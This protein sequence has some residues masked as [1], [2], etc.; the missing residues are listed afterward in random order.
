M[1]ETSFGFLII[2]CYM[3]KCSLWPS[4]PVL[5]LLMMSWEFSP[6]I[7]ASVLRIKREMCEKGFSIFQFV[8]NHRQ[9]NTV[10]ENHRKSLI[11]HCELTTFTFWVDKSSLKMPKIVN[12]AIFLKIWS[13]RLNSVTRQVNFKMTINGVK[14]QNYKIQMTW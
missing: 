5:S 3:G 1:L 10:F 4:T 7:W 2:R 11:Q 9:S 8:G 13:L 14:C 12:L 6:W